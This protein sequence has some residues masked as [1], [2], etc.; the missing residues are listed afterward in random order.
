MH[1][2]PVDFLS[3][4]SNSFSLV[5]RDQKTSKTTGAFLITVR[6][7]LSNLLAYWIKDCRIVLEGT[8]TLNHDNIFFNPKSGKPFTQQKFSKYLIKAF[9]NV[10]H[11]TLNMQIVRRGIVEGLIAFESFFFARYK[12]LLARSPFFDRVA[13]VGLF[14]AHWIEITSKNIFP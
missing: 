1:L 12:R 3:I 5:I 7:P 13:V 2:S 9:Q 10:C 6:P 11:E 4:T 14:H 8:V